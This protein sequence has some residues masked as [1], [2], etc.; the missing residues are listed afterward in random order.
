M[1]RG[2]DQDIEGVRDVLAF[3]GKISAGGLISCGSHGLALARLQKSGSNKSLLLGMTKRFAASPVLEI[4]TQRL[5]QA[6]VSVACE[7]QEYDL[8]GAE[9]PG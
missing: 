7:I 9:A 4:V 5:G 1:P 8:F 2:C 3:D 6:K